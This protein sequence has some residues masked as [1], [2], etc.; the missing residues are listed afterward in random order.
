[1]KKRVN[2]RGCLLLCL[3]VEGVRNQRHIVV[4]TAAHGNGQRLTSP[5]KEEKIVSVK[6]VSANYNLK[7]K[8]L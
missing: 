2:V 6:N 8:C 4:Q 3:M 7:K 5:C 1:M